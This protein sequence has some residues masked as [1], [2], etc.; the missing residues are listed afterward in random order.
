MSNVE[1]YTQY[2]VHVPERGYIGITGVLKS[3]PEGFETPKGA[4]E[5]LKSSMDK[6]TNMGCP[7]IAKTLRIVTC[8]VTVTYSDWTTLE[9]IAV[10]E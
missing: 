8:T 1:T 4:L 10:A 7:E 9:P 2:A 3:K 5:Q 6:Y